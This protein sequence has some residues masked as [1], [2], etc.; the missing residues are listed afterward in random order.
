M[1]SKKEKG[2]EGRRAGIIDRLHPQYSY[3]ELCPKIVKKHPRFDCCLIIIRAWDYDVNI[4][5]PAFGILDI[6][7]HGIKNVLCTANNQ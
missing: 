2:R 3:G 1:Q 5:N 7:P 6:Y 4:N